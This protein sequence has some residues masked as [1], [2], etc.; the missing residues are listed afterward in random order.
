[1]RLDPTV[2]LLQ[3]EHRPGRQPADT[4]MPPTPRSAEL[5]RST[6]AVRPATEPDRTAIREVSAVAFGHEQGPTIV[7]LLDA[8]DSTGHTR[9]D[10]VA[11]QDGEVVGHVRLSR[12]WVDA[13]RALVEVLVLSPLSVLPDR[14]RGGTGTTLVA[15]ALALAERLGAPA[16]FLEGSPAY[17]GA[18]GFTGG[19][20][21]GFGRP[22]ARIPDPAFQVALL[23]GHEEW[24]TGALV[25]CDPFWAEDCVG[26]RDP[27]LAELEEQLG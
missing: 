4:G 13:R 27:L 26:L 15:A 7:R 18:R 8:L 2:L 24:M 23:P 14:Q 1:M 17:Y 16:V 20:R 10:L 21:L 19:S 3:Y 11:E 9:A 12:S 25:Y 6:T 5:A 22:S